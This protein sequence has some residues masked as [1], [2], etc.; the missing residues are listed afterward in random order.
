[1]RT[2]LL[3]LDLCTVGLSPVKHICSQG[4]INEYEYV[5]ADRGILTQHNTLI[6]AHLPL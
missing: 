2:S 5:M 3:S 1:M 6:Y 4:V